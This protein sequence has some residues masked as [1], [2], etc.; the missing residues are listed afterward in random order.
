MFA[1]AFF[2]PELLSQYSRLE[3]CIAALQ[4]VEIKL[5]LLGTTLV[6]ATVLKK[7]HNFELSGRRII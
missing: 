5:G 2:K 1:P 7:M 3:H 4:A 6:G